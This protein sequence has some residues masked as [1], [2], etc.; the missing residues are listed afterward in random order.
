MFP[1]VERMS[2]LSLEGMSTSTNSQSQRREDD[3]AEITYESD[4]DT[5]IDFDEASGIATFPSG[6]RYSVHGLDTGTKNTVVKA[7]NTSSK[8]TLR[9]CS[10][11]GQGYVFLISETIEHH[12]RTPCSGGPYDSPSCSCQQD[13]RSTVLQHPC[14]H[15]LWLC[16]QILS[17]LV[18]LP[19]DPYTW[20]IDGYTTKHG[21]VCDFISDFHFDV[22]ADS[23]RCDVM[24]GGSTKP[25]PHRIQ[26]AREILATLSSNPV[27][28]YRPDLTGETLG[29]GLV[30]EGDLEETIFRMLLD[31]D[32]FLAYFLAS[33]RNHEPLNPRFR[34]FRDRADAAL[35][36]Y[37]NYIKAS[38]LERTELSKTPQWCYKTFKD[39]S[40]QLMSIVIHLERELDD[41]DCRAAASTLVYIL[42]QVVRRNEDHEAARQGGDGDNRGDAQ[43]TAAKKINLCSDLIVDHSHNFIIDILGGLQREFVAHLLPD[44]S[45]IERAIT[46]TNVPQSYLDQL[47]GI[48]SRIRTADSR[49]GSEPAESSRKRM[50][51]DN[52]RHPKRVR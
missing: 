38:D 26:T 14:R 22:L 41:Y 11:R 27:G 23:L 1:P 31:N 17:Q 24:A 20:R 49:F 25:R 46:N 2:Q 48:I 18:P 6:T 16:D 9:G 15:T 51:E 45:R 52:D 8:L 43:P 34:R 12:V 36:A 30:K 33:M 50:S 19:D 10:P 35:D 4:I 13:E 32:S 5:S 47:R 21:N 37:D 3:S 39:I 42:E 29:K 44:L 7:L 40:E 28:T